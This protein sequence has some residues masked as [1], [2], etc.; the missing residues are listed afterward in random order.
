M[1]SHVNSFLAEG[2]TTDRRGPGE[3]TMG[4]GPF[5]PFKGLGVT[6][7]FGA[8]LIGLLTSLGPAGECA[9]VADETHAIAQRAQGPGQAM[10]EGRRFVTVPIPISDPSIGTGLAV[11]GIY[12]H[13]R[14]EGDTGAQTTMSGL[15]GMYTSTDSWL[16]GA[17]HEG[18]YSQDRYRVRGFGGYGEF[19]L[20]YYGIG[21]DSI[22]RDNPIDYGAQA[23]MF[24]PRVLFRLPWDNWFLGPRYA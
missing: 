9:E 20:K 18:F 8:T 6:S 13:P 16:A 11:A 4:W 15:V 22:L 5:S 7:L 12:L 10:A 3:H 23:V 17:F 19:N 21:E 24:M 1:T 14:R 2:F